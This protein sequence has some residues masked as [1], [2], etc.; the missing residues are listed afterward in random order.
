MRLINKF[1]IKKICFFF[2]FVTIFTGCKKDF[3]DLE[4]PN[5]IDS[6]I[7]NDEGAVN[8]FL[9]KGY[10]L[11]IPQWPTPGGIHNT[12]DE[13]NNGFAAL[14]TGTLTDNSV[15]DIGTANAINN[16]RYFDIRRCNTAIEGINSGTLSTEIKNK[17]K[18]QFFFL[19]GMIYFNL[20]RL[21]GGVPLILQAQDIT[22]EELN[23]PR[24]KTSECF[25]AIVKDLDSAAAYLPVVWPT[26]EKGKVARA[27][28]FAL[29]G[30][31]LMYW[32]SPQFN[33]TNLS[34]R[35][36]D[37]Y[38]ANKAAYDS[39]VKDGLA[40]H[41]VYANIFVDE[42]VGTNKEIL[43]VRVHDAI[44][45]SPGRGTNT[46]YITRPRSE[47][48]TA[49]GGGSN[50]PTWN[51]VQA[52]TMKDG[53]PITASSV[54]VPYNSV[55][56]WKD[57]DPRF[58]ASISYN[59]DIWPLSSKAGRKQ[60]NYT[61]VTDEA[62]GLT[63]TGFYCKRLC[64]PLLAPIQT[65]YNSNSGG[66]SGM[67]WIEMRFAEV[68]ANLAETANET[69]RLVEA[70]DMIRKL[71]QRAG[72]TTSGTLDYGMSVAT[73]MTSMRT[74]IMNERMVEF[75]MEGKRYHDLRRTRLLHLLTGTT[76]QALRWA[77]K[78]PNTV[79]TL[80]GLTN[81]GI[82]RRDTADLNNQVVYTNLYTTSFASLD[83]TPINIPTSYYFYPLPTAFR[84]S[85][86][87]LEQT[88]GWPG[89]SFDPLQ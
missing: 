10:D 59:G 4:D 40:L 73:D 71:R 61:G 43:I 45:V 70:K 15:T 3:F 18:G 11:M 53:L 13:L 51:L 38:Q 25:N 35:W 14:L 81:A 89:G 60:W 19:R 16:S 85:S 22:G 87:L 50:Q 55:L 1:T 64:N 6:Q 63:T 31:A 72:I 17:L 7:W 82:K 48:A 5:G 65:L 74:L 9:N 79:A 67:D 42:N 54:A 47:T 52:Y 30:K 83:A 12:S 66:G 28:A 2:L 69:G 37:A 57:R 21:Y 8:L 49:G 76:R 39:C 26:N 80:E 62:A 27:A 75:A 20:V 56:F 44:S 77:V 84:N 34:S 32:A 78:A 33:P 86:F 58:A 29:K 41:P 68:I 88:S 24:S 36:E 46:E 23:V